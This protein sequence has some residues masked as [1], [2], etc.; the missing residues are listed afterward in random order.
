MAR[1][2]QR[3]RSSRRVVAPRA[4][5]LPPVV[6]VPSDSDGVDSIN[7][8]HLYKLDETS[9]STAT[10]SIGSIDGAIDGATLGVSGATSKTDTAYSFD[11]SNDNIVVGSDSSFSPQQF[12][13][14][15]WIKATGNLDN[16]TYNNV[17]PVSKWGSTANEYLIWTTAQDGYQLSLRVIDGLDSDATISRSSLDG[18][19]N[20]VAA[21]FD[22]S[23]KIY[24]NGSKKDQGQSIGD[25]SKD[26][27]QNF[28]IGSYASDK[29]FQGEI[30]D[31]RF[32]DIA[33]T[34]S[35]VQQLYNSYL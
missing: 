3:Q 12:S 4:I 32:Y 33:L 28:Q 24:L 20:H 11:G 13:I 10:D 29:Y 35:Q 34:D 7:P 27:A 8:I 2:P 6:N 30:D 21:V 17:S 18:T 16:G 19:W 1:K 14:T 9:G 25:F 22:G 5:R 23:S 15:V 26:T 31:I